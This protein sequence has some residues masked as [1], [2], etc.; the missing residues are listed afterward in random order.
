[1]NLMNSVSDRIALIESCHKYL[2]NLGYPRSVRGSCAAR[3]CL[4]P[5][6]YVEIVKWWSD[7]TERPFE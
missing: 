5:S 3:A 1:M 4:H 2:R 6:P 7:R